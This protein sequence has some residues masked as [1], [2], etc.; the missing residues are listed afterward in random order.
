MNEVHNTDAIF[1]SYAYNP[2]AYKTVNHAYS[3]VDPPP[4][5]AGIFQARC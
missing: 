1:T 4:F 5:R 2:H 3:D